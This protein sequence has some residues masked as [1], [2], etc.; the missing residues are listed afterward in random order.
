MWFC[1][2]V[3]SFESPE[4]LVRGLH[5]DEGSVFKEDVVNV[6]G[7]TAPEKKALLVLLRHARPLQGNAVPNVAIR[8]RTLP[9]MAEPCSQCQLSRF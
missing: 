9:I 3:Y 8:D 2:Y 4:S 6:F 7:T 5:C 1:F